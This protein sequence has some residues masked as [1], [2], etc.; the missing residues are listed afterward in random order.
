[1]TKE[2]ELQ[3]LLA[4]IKQLESEGTTVPK[5]AKKKAIVKNNQVYVPMGA[6]GKALTPVHLLAPEKL[7]ELNRN[8][9]VNVIKDLRQQAQDLRAKANELELSANQKEKEIENGIY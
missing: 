5:P 3:E 7:A 2:Q 6:S 1:M 8:R 4:Q 9:K